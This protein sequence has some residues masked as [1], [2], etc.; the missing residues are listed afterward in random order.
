MKSKSDILKAR[1]KPLPS[2]DS[3]RGIYYPPPKAK[4]GCAEPVIE[5]DEG[6]HRLVLDK[7]YPPCDSVTTWTSEG[8][9]HSQKWSSDVIESEWFDGFPEKI[10]TS[11]LGPPSVKAIAL[12]FFS[13]LARSAK[14]GFKTVHRE[15]FEERLTLCRGCPYWSDVARI[16]TGKCSHP[17]CGCTKLK[18][19]LASQSCPQ[20]WWGVAPETTIKHR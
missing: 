5:L 4:G 11:L 10:H 9:P 8:V 3:Q 14:D 1:G 7:D 17:E 20:G 12:N 18:L 2:K 16:G 15:I 19:H 13:A 6:K